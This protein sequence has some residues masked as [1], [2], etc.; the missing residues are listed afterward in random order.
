MAF[1]PD[2][3]PLSLGMGCGQVS[4]LGGC[5][6]EGHFAGG[7]VLQGFVFILVQLALQWEKKLCLFK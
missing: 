2:P 4:Y 6:V 3:A 1:S 7:G 5:E